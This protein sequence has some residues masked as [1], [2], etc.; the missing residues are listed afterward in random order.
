M[1]RLPL[2]ALAT[3]LAAGCAHA[4]RSD[5]SLLGCWRAEAQLRT[6][7]DGRRV[8]GDRLEIAVEAPPAPDALPGLVRLETALVRVP[9][10]EA[11]ECLPQ[12]AR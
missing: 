7:E 3:L 6:F 11:G 4:P 12:P 5:A 8:D 9:A 1:S 2:A 10:A